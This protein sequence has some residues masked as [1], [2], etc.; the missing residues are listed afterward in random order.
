MQAKLGNAQ[1]PVTVYYFSGTGNS[2]YIAKSII[3][4]IS[5]RLINI[6]TVIKQNEINNDDNIIGIVF[7]VYYGNI[8]NIIQK[9]V[10]KLKQI[11][12]KYIFVVVTYGG[13]KGRSIRVIKKLV[14][15]NNGRISAAYGIH[16][17]QNTFRKNA[18]KP[19]VLYQKADT[20]IPII[21]RNMQKR[22]SGFFSTELI[23]DILQRPL[24]YLL[25]PSYKKYIRQTAG[26]RNN[27]SLMEL[28]Y[29]MDN[30]FHV[31]DECNGCGHCAEICPVDNIELDRGRPVWLHHCVNC[32]ACYSFCP[33]KAIESVM[34]QRSYFYRHPDYSP[35]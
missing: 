11:S 22:A 2:Y 15:A 26:G 27:E 18:D 33:Q 12:S 24:S 31:N 5:G 4:G 19:E 7:P 8:P 29:R 32:I 23:A 28:Q 9:F 3:E 16:M 17:P 35:I 30:T 21:R 20:I 34:V 1:M 13:G 25:I 10:S 14:K 6:A